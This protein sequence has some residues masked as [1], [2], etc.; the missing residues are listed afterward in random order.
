VKTTPSTGIAHDRGCEQAKGP[1]CV[2]QCGGTGHSF[3]ILKRC[4]EHPGLGSLGAIVKDLDAILGK[5]QPDFSAGGP[6]LRP[7]R[8]TEYFDPPLN[9][10]Q[11]R[12]GRTATRFETLMLDE[13]LHAV[14]L[15]T[16]KDKTTQHLSELVCALTKDC[17]TKMMAKIV[18]AGG[19]GKG[20]EAPH[21]WCSLVTAHLDARTAGSALTLSPCHSNIVLPRSGTLRTPRLLAASH[22]V[23][24][25]GLDLIDQKLRGHSVGLSAGEVDYVLSLVAICCC[26]DMWR[27]PAVVK[28]ALSRHVPITKHVRIGHHAANFTDVVDRWRRKSHW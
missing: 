14:L 7:T 5:F 1:D 22:T 3:D 6:N 26:P 11:L 9:S 23:G 15:A 20:V 13:S 21:V 18:S 25:D 4:I 27:H 17:V 19:I 24:G 12:S 28:H 10:K 16:A 2:C 8:N